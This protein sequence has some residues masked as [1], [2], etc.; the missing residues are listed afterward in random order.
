MN[1]ETPFC[2]ASPAPTRA[3]MQSVTEISALSQGTKL[4]TCAST[5][6]QPTPRMYVLLPPYRCHSNEAVHYFGTACNS[7]ALS[8]G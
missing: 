6:M 3:R 8:D 5:A 4:P 7:N 2:T 1:V